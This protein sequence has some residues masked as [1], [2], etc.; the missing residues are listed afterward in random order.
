MNDA[1]EQNGSGQAQWVTAALAK[2]RRISQR[3]LWAVSVALTILLLVVVAAGV[4]VG[5]S[6]V[7]YTKAAVEAADTMR[8]QAAAKVAESAGDLA[9]AT[10][11]TD[12]VIGE[13]RRLAETLQQQETARLRESEMFKA[14]MARF[15]AWVDAENSR[16][17]RTLAATQTSL[18]QLDRAVAQQGLALTRMRD[19]LTNVAAIVAVAATRP[20]PF[21]VAPPVPVGVHEPIQRPGLSEEQLLDSSSAT[22]AVTSL[23]KPVKVSEPAPMVLPSGDRYDGAMRDGLPDGQGTCWYVK[24]SKY[25][26]QFRRGQKNG[27]GV[28]TFAGGDTYTGEYVDDVRQG[29]GVYVYRDGSRYEGVFQNGTRNGKGRYVF[30]SGGEYVGEFKN[31]KKHGIGSHVFADGTRM[32]GYW[33]EDRYVGPAVPSGK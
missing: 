10:A 2:E 28:F 6:V 30:K 1:Q 20:V 12:A 11:R 14:E 33:K 26:G 22:G 21:A 19:D 17:S 29:Q 8:I 24:G 31:G 4:I 18:D 15:S 9:A 3:R 5:R 25:T 32:D 7:G 13:V 27:R 16:V 23:P